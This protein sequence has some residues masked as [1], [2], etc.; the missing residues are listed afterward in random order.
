MSSL[1]DI[2]DVD[3]EPLES[4]AIQRSRDV[5]LLQNQSLDTRPTNSL[6]RTERSTTQ[7]S[8]KRKRPTRIS[9]PSSS[10]GSSRSG[11]ARRRSSGATELMDPSGYGQGGSQNNA[12]PSLPRGLEADQPV[13][14]TPVTGRV[15]KAKKGQPVHVC[16]QCDEPKAFT[17]AEHLR[18]HQLSHEQAKL[19]CTFPDCE[20][21][22]HRP[23]LLSRHMSR[24]EIQGD[25]PYRTSDYKPIDNEQRSRSSSTSSNPRTPPQKYSPQ[26]PNMNAPN[27][28]YASPNIQA[29][30]ANASAN[31]RLSKEYEPIM[32][33]FQAVNVSESSNQR[34]HSRTDGSESSGLQF[35][36][37]RGSMT[38][39][40]LNTSTYHTIPMST[41]MTSDF[42]LS[43]PSTLGPAFEQSTYSSFASNVYPGS[44]PGDIPPLTLQVPDPAYN[45]SLASPPYNSSE[46][47]WSTPSD[48][49]RQG[50]AWPHDR[51]LQAGWAAAESHSTAAQQQQQPLFIAQNM[52]LLRQQGGL[53]VVPEQFQGQF[54]ST[55]RQFGNSIVTSQPMDEQGGVEGGGDIVS[56]ARS[57]RNQE[58]STKA[59]GSRS[60][61]K[62]DQ[63]RGTSRT[64]SMVSLWMN[65]SMAIRKDKG[66]CG[67][68]VFGNN[69]YQ[70][71]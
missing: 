25:G 54:M 49:S 39:H 9:K 32:G 1:R 3:V 14:Y 67:L 50:T 10:A 53:H 64:S 22:F 57:A 15:S 52:N 4:Q 28:N 5:A 48:V 13:R 40:A 70:G 6:S 21:V 68:A 29:P 27:S 58:M 46:S 44:G 59:N 41:N 16:E 71:L 19:P 37:A 45:P 26:R 42:L 8:V 17:R 62:M 33:S 24:H 12:R 43:H 66:S 47:N 18:R 2:M 69:F 20:R 61:T 34:P 35:S 7:R 55:T 60:T 30:T 23:D 65:A 31:M 38:S 11:T 63:T 51:A 36:P 56:R